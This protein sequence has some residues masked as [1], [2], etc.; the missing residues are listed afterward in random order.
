MHFLMRLFIVWI[1]IG[2]MCTTITVIHD[3]LIE[4]IKIKKVEICGMITMTM[5]GFV[6]VPIIIY[7]F[8]QEYSEKKERKRGKRHG[9]IY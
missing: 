5:M 4:K 1:A 9:R 2:G 3:V 8:V 6:S 7:F